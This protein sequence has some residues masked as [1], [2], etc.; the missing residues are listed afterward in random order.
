MELAQKA[1]FLKQ[2][3]NAMKLIVLSIH[4]VATSVP[5]HK[6]QYSSLEAGGGEIYIKM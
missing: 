5:S 1:L 4:F 6:F 2:T 3:Q